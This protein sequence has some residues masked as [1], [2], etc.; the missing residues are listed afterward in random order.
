MNTGNN[1]NKSFKLGGQYRYSP[2]IITQKTRFRGFDAEYSLNAYNNES[3][4]LNITEFRSFTGTASSQKFN[5]KYNTNSDG[6]R[7]EFNLTIPDVKRLIFGSKNYSQLNFDLTNKL[8]FKSD[9]NTNRVQDLDTL[10]NVYR[11]NAYL[12]NQIR[13]DVIEET[14][15]LRIQ[16]SFQKSLSNRYYKSFT[17][18][19]HPKQLLISQDNKSDRSFRNLKRNYSRFAPDA[20][21]SFYNHQYGETSRNYDLNYSTKINIPNINQ[22]APL[23]DSTNLYYL[24]RGNINLKEGVQR[25]L[26]FSFSSNDQR[27]KNTLNYY[28][29]VSAGLIANN[30][31]DS[32]LIDEQNRRTVYLVNASGH[33]YIN[34]YGNVRKAYKLRSSELQ[35]SLNVNFNANRNPGYT[36]N[37]FTFS[38]NLNTYNNVNINYTY[39]SY[40]AVALGQSYNTSHSKQEAFNTEYSGTNMG[41]TL[42]SSYNVTKRFTLNSN[43]T[44]NKNSSSTAD[45]IN[46]TIWN[47]S[48]VYRFLKGNNMEFKLS[49]LDLLRQNNSV[50]NYGNSNSFTIGTQNVLKQYFMTTLSYYPRQFGKKSKAKK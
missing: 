7:Q 28:M 15:G 33:K 47:A 35:L 44:F 19:F 38:T 14:P 17:I 48:A 18:R 20:G 11:T 13:T 45:D 26:S 10:T 41:T 24:Q 34:G 22:L 2:Y 31:V 12:D 50:I 32:L 8:V 42:S 39:K 25:E 6:L 36:N 40:L 43:V 29:N 49:A 21:L 16:K 23:T 4:Q 9:K 5:R 1:N 46:F 30:I 27:S 3:E 37:I